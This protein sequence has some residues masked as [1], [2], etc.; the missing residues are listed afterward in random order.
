MAVASMFGP[1]TPTPEVKVNYVCSDYH[2]SCLRQ[3][4]PTRLSGAW[5]IA[6]Q[7][8]NR[9]TA[10]SRTLSARSGGL[11]MRSSRTEGISDEA[12][13][14]TWDQSYV[15]SNAANLWGNDPVPFVQK[16]VDLFLSSGANA[17]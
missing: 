5:L 15:L 10:G 8:G 13:K 14:A 7:V 17:I 6:L 11:P 3:Q 9:T 16:A 4:R 12:S 2:A 1:R